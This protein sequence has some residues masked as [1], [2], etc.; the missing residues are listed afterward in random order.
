[1]NGI[2]CNRKKSVQRDI[3]RAVGRFNVMKSLDHYEFGFKLWIVFLHL[4]IGF[5]KMLFLGPTD[6]AIALQA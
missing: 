3:N 6:N 4:L 5:G 1:M 2:A